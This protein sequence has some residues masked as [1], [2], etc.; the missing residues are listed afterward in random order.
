M[1]TGGAGGGAAHVAPRH[2]IPHLLPLLPRCWR[3]GHSKGR[4]AVLTTPGRHRR[5]KQ[6]LPEQ[7]R[8]PQQPRRCQIHAVRHA[9]VALNR[10]PL[11]LRVSLLPSHPACCL[12]PFASLEPKSASGRACTSRR[13]GQHSRRPN[14][15]VAGQ[16]LLGEID[17]KLLPHEALDL[18]VHRN[19]GATS[20]GLQ[21]GA[22][23]G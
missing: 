14:E 4:P 9:S 23:R 12:H 1:R 20:D 17:L 2:P 6:R 7:Q 11:F 16:E 3:P 5:Q 18:P 10:S 22:G 21:G 15:E 8:G 13:R 19:A